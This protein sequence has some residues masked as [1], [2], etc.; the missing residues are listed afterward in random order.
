MYERLEKVLEAV[1]KPNF[2]SVIYDEDLTFNTSSA[3][4][5]GG[6]M[7]MTVLGET[8]KIEDITVLGETWKLEDISKDTANASNL[9]NISNV[10]GVQNGK[11]ENDQTSLQNCEIS[12][13]LE[14]QQMSTR[15]VKRALVSVDPSS[16]KRQKVAEGGCGVMT[17]PGSL[18]GADSIIET[19]PTSKRKK[20]IAVLTEMKRTSR[21]TATKKSPRMLSLASTPAVKL[22]LLAD[23]PNSSFSDRKVLCRVIKYPRQPQ[24][25]ESFGSYIQPDVEKA[26]LKSEKQEDEDD[27]SPKTARRVQKSVTKN[28]SLSLRVS[29]TSSID[30]EEFWRELK[31]DV[32]FSNLKRK[33]F[34]GIIAN[35]ENRNRCFVSNNVIHRI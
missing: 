2:A 32:A 14:P 21:K 35:L 6:G 12:F 5:V 10:V 26:E 18:K 22:S 27:V 24:L 29:S 4:A 20:P 15:G 1:E 30:V 34:D 3:T 28:L 31:A 17:P 9:E 8:T 16:V 33:R 13:H 11:A 19:P 7:N 25:A 23:S